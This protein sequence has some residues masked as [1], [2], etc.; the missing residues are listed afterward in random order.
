MK[1]RRYFRF[2]LR[3]FFV[4]L[5]VLAVWLGVQVEWKRDRQAARLWIAQHSHNG[6]TVSPYLNLLQLNQQSVPSY[7]THVRPL[8]ERQSNLPWNL[9]L[10]GLKLLGEK[11]M[12]WIRL[13][14]ETVSKAD[15]EYVHRLF[16]EATV[17]VAAPFTVSGGPSAP[18]QKTPIVS[19][20]SNP[21]ETP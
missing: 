4:L 16:P 15:V 5:T 14:Q 21:G 1:P 10:L 12:P 3:T 6:P 20:P 13:D 2:S 7:Q 19:K 11:A 17:Q 8:I 18:S 9:R